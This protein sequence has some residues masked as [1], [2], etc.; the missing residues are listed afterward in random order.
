LRR[1]I[2][3]LFVAAMLA[4]MLLTAKPAHASTTF[5]V[6]FGSDEAD[7]NAGDG[8]CDVAA[9]IAGSQCTLRAAIQEANAL[10]GADTINFNMLGSSG[11]STLFP[12][13]PLPLISDRVTI[14]G[15][16]QPGASPNTLAKGTNAVLKIQLNGTNAGTARNGLEIN[17]PG[18]VVKGLAIHRFGGHGIVLFALASGTKIEGN[19]LGT[20]DSGAQGLGN[21]DDG[22]FVINSDNHTVGGT[23]PA[24]RNLISANKG[25]GVKLDAGVTGTRVQGNLI[26]TKKDGVGSLANSLSGVNISSSA[27]NPVSSNTIAFN[28]LNGVRIPGNIDTVNGNPVLGNSIF[29]NGQLGIDLG[30][31]GVTPNDPGDPD[32]GPNALQNFPVLSSA[33]TV[34]GKTTV[35]G[36]LDSTPNKTFLVQ[37][38]SNPSG[39]EGKK[40]LGQTGVT[41]DGSGN[42]SFTFSPATAV[43]AGQ[44]IT[45]TAT[46][47]EA[48]NLNTSEFSAPKTVAAT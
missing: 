2:L 7:L 44:T 12:R 33:K 17:A 9:N 41:T 39:N 46:L 31:N 10:P 28:A 45:A 4:T 5:T 23:S 34:S 37:F 35:Q 3:A 13:S 32:S 19:F 8:V 21:G 11:V 16:S 36:K 24:A 27:N 14:D 15:Y 43:P 48:N 1:M 42:A 18:S 22:I 25:D 20:D 30:A 6:N 26:G 29:S 38:S 47:S 40:F